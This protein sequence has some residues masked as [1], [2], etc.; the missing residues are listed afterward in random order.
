MDQISA[1]RIPLEHR[2]DLTNQ[3]Y[4]RF[5]RQF[6]PVD[7]YGKERSARG[8]R[9]HSLGPYQQ[10]LGRVSV[11]FRLSPSLA[12]SSG[13]CREAVSSRPSWINCSAGPSKLLQTVVFLPGPLDLDLDHGHNV[14]LFQKDSNL[15]NMSLST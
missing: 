12:L 7:L 3:T 8:P 2:R 10:S 14:S 9:F 11:H 4:L 13:V 1:L 15:S 5:C 6:S